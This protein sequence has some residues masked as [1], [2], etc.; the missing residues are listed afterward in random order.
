MRTKGIFQGT[1]YI[2]KPKKVTA[3]T[4]TYNENRV[5]GLGSCHTVVY[6]GKSKDGRKMAVKK[7]PI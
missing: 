2:D 6:K 4:I 1:Q 5:I 7:I 3:G